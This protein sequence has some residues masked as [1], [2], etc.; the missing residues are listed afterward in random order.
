MQTQHKFKELI[1]KNNYK[2]I[3]C[4]MCGFW[5]V[6]PIPSQAEL[7]AYY[8]TKYY[9]TLGDNRSMTDKLRNPDGFYAI[10]YEDRLRRILKLL[11]SQMP[12]L[13]LDIGAG[14]GDFLRFMKRNGWEVQGLEV[15]RSAFQSIKD[16]T[17]LNIKQGEIDKILKLDFRPSS[18]VTLNNVLEHLRDPQ[19]MIE[20][21]RKHLL[22]PKGILFIVVPND[23]NILQDIL[24]KTV[25]KNN[26]E[27]HYYWIAPPDHLNYWT[28]KTIRKFLLRCGFKIRYFTVDF[29]MEIFPLMGEDYITNPE[30]GRTAHLKRVQFEKFLCKANFNKFKDR[31]FETLARIGIG[32]DMQ[33]L[34]ER[35]E[36]RYIG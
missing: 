36:D 10:Q 34:I 6:Y 12:R 25:L 19:W 35:K 22:L 2:I 16:R 3:N 14:Y 23:F 4:K 5:H 26:K 7:N 20:T 21:I 27:K 30:V 13:V 1:V 18:V 31:L 11:P 24:M 29:P 9:E 17:V 32:R 15:S 28:S 8:K 33:M